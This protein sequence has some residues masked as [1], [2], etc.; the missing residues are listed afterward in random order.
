MMSF[1]YIDYFPCF[2]DNCMDVVQGNLKEL[3]RKKTIDLSHF[4][5]DKIE[6]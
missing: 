1:Q 3:G 6:S 4:E 2:C 5:K